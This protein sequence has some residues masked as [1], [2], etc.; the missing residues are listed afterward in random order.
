MVLEQHRTLQRQIY[1]YYIGI[2]E[3]DEPSKLMFRILESQQSKLIHL[4]E[5]TLSKKYHDVINGTITPF[6]ANNIIP[7][8]MEDYGFML[9][10]K[11][12][13]LQAA[14]T[15]ELDTEISFQMYALDELL[16]TLMRN[17]NIC[18]GW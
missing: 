4:L 3:D 14:R 13:W 6:E 2:V 1:G 5:T 17:T 12:F 15:Y 11:S 8:L 16:D 10:I 9:E 18:L 7:D